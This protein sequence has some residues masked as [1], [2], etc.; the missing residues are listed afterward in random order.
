M[1]LYL[2]YRSRKILRMWQYDATQSVSDYH[3][4]N[5]PP[6]WTNASTCLGTSVPATYPVSAALMPL[7]FSADADSLHTDATSTTH[8]LWGLGVQTSS[9][10]RIVLERPRPRPRRLQ[11]YRAQNPD[12]GNCP[13]RTPSTSLSYK[14]VVNVGQSSF[15]SAVTW[16]LA[17]QHGRIQARHM[18]PEQM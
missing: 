18:L 17:W 1:N 10:L 5:N 2:E 14:T 11:A 13:I 12:P 3:W 4:G 6:H 7:I 8:P 9:H 16:I 15:H